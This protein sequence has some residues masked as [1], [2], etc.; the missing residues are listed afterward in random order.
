MLFLG[1]SLILRYWL[2]R[3]K[4][5]QE[6][7]QLLLTQVDINVENHLRRMMRVSDTIYYLS[8]KSTNFLEESV[9]DDLYLLYGEN[10]DMVVS[11]SLFNAGGGLIS[12]APLT[13]L[14]PTVVVNQ[15]D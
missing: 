2:S 14:K 6:N 7:S 4:Q 3:N 1:L 5:A 15:Q 11:V 13:M 10:R 9:N 8:I 12:S